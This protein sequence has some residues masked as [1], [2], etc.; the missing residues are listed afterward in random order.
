MGGVD[1]SCTASAPRLR[2]N[3]RAALNGRKEIL[4]LGK[5]RARPLPRRGEGAAG[6][7]ADTESRAGLSP[8][9]S[10]PRSLLLPTPPFAPQRP[11]AARPV[12]PSAPQLRSPGAPWR[13]LRRGAA[14]R[15][16][17]RSA[18][19]PGISPGRSP[20][21]RKHRREPRASQGRPQSGASAP[22]PTRI[23]QLRTASIT[24]PT[25]AGC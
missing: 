10:F 4:I 1:A 22:R 5:G 3:P 6:G 7:A 11:A 8:A 16:P 25:A 9:P 14:A 2:A 12:P 15:V 19:G 13:R 17:S 20:G 18:E 24:R 21:T 23:Q